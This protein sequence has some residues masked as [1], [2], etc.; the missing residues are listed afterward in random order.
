[1]C[2]AFAGGFL[3]AA[4]YLPVLALLI[5]FG[6][7]GLFMLL[8][9]ASMG[10]L[11]VEDEGDRLAIRFGPLPL[12]R[13]RVRYDDILEAEMGRTTF[14]DGWGIHW[15]PW[16]GWVWNVCGHDCVLLRLKRGKLK[17]GTDDAEGLAG[18]VRSRI[19]ST[20]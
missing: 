4:I 18:F 9:C 13:R 14:L 12:F 6:V 5:T 11:T 10:H 19:S 15:S 8:L 2:C 1:M 17:I 16:G 20:R 3:L 7:T